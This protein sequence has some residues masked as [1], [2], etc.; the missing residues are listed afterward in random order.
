MF[1]A[2][3]GT[4]PPRGG[5]RVFRILG[6]RSVRWE[7]CSACWEQCS[8]C[9]RRP[10][11]RGREFKTRRDDPDFCKIKRAQG[12]STCCH[13]T[14]RSM[15]RRRRVEKKTPNAQRPTSNPELKRHSR[16][17]GAQQRTGAGNRGAGAP[18]A[19][20]GTLGRKTSR[21]HGAPLTA[22]DSTG[23]VERPNRTVGRCIGAV[24]GSSHT[25]GRSNHAVK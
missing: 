5:K 14:E 19:V 20:R 16:D 24:E 2:C 11:A 12:W 17:D 23:A 4:L 25:V 18:G 10:S 6:P 13:T 1:P 15:G 7:E 21:L 9:C 8:A 22:D 3:V